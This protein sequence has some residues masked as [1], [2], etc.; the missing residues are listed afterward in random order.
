MK[1]IAES[2]QELTE[3]QKLGN[4]LLITGPSMTYTLHYGTK[5]LLCVVPH[6][7][8]PGMW[9]MEWPDGHRSDFCNIT[10]IKDAAEVICARGR[11]ANM[12]HWKRHPYDKPLEGRTRV[13]VRFESA[14]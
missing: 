10:R 3:R 12:L 1:I 13:R 7:T 14:A 11:D 9:L 5:A 6:S 2:V 4:P 8:H